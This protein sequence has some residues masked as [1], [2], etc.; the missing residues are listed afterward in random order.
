MSFS[1]DPINYKKLKL[2]YPSFVV[3]MISTH[4]YSQTMLF[5]LNPNTCSKISK[6]NKNLLMNNTNSKK[7]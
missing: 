3:S 1:R 6:E 5:Y 4:K 2:D 7:S